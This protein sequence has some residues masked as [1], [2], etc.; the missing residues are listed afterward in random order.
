MIHQTIRTGL[1]D[2]A[3]VW[4]VAAVLAACAPRQD[5]AVSSRVA[6]PAAPVAMIVSVRATAA[7]LARGTILGA[8]G[9]A[10][11][12]AAAACCEFILR[13]EDGR[14]W[15]VVQGNPDGLRVGERVALVADRR[16][17]LVRAPG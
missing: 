5:A 11:P 6:A 14:T 8:L 17:R 4:A 1:R 16:T 10:G 15:S 13:A 9:G 3:A 7:G 2:A 12:A